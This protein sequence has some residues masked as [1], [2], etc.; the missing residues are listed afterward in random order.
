[1]ASDLPEGEASR[2]LG[3]GTDTAGAFAYWSAGGLDLVACK[4]GVL[5][6][7]LSCSSSEASE[8]SSSSLPESKLSL[9]SAD[10]PKSKALEGKAA[11]DAS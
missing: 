3:T 2:L 4:A 1:M 8:K 6:G 10:G 11:S 9:R 5:T 7:C